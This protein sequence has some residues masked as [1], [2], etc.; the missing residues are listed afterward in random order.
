[1]T[2][3]IGLPD[4]S[5]SILRSSMLSNSLIPQWTREG[6]IIIHIPLSLLFHIHK[7]SY[8]LN[9]V[10]PNQHVHPNDELNK[11]WP[12]YIRYILLMQ[13]LYPVALLFFLFLV[14][15]WSHLN[16]VSC[17]D[18]FIHWR[19][20]CKQSCY[21]SENNTEDRYSLFFPQSGLSSL[22]AV[23]LLL[24]GFSYWIQLCLWLVHS[25]SVV[26]F[27]NNSF[28]WSNRSTTFLRV[29]E[30]S[31]TKTMD[32]WINEKKVTDQLTYWISG[33]FEA[34][35][36]TP[37]ICKAYFIR[38]QSLSLRQKENVYYTWNAKGLFIYNG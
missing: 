4:R 1:M 25:L 9:I 20:W 8:H 26:Q 23:S 17:T 34:G 12:P 30:E 31:P 7:S 11:P 16:S 21:H 13:S 6:E 33:T 18:S 15:C 35:K 37:L 14:Y 28:C 19:L 2:A 38:S 10:S 29:F 36:V 24:T 27:K 32:R 22:F 5:A 3:Y